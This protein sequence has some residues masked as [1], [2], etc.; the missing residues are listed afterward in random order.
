LL[1]SLIQDKP[2]SAQQATASAPADQVTPGRVEDAANTAGNAAWGILFSL[3]LAA[4]AA[5][6]G[7]DSGARPVKVTMVRI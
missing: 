5:I 6:A 2:H 1:L 7:G 4:A 3:G